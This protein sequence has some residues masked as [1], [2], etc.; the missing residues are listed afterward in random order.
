MVLLSLRLLLQNVIALA[1]PEASVARPT[2][3]VSATAVASAQPHPPTPI[4]IDRPETQTHL[5]L[6]ADYDPKHPRLMP[7]AGIPFFL[8]SFANAI[9]ANVSKPGVGAQAEY[10]FDENEFEL[11]PR[12]YLIL[13]DRGKGR[14]TPKYGDILSTARTI[15]DQIGFFVVKRGHMKMYKEVKVKIHRMGHVMPQS[16]LGIMDFMYAG[17]SNTLEDE[18]F[19]QVFNV[20]S[21]IVGAYPPQQK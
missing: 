8:D 2:S 20:S 16:P 18:G 7:E 10:N 17:Q 9:E 5:V 12:N 11:Q 13:Y 19:L 1:L 4:S 15:R 21:P 3:I 6:Y 14:P